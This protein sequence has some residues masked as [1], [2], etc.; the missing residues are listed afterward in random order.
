MTLHLSHLESKVVLNTCN[1][2][3]CVTFIIWFEVF[4]SKLS[5]FSQCPKYCITNDLQMTL[6]QLEEGVVGCEILS[7]R[8]FITFICSFPWIGYLCPAFLNC[9]TV[10]PQI[11]LSVYKSLLE[12]PLGL[13]RAWA[14]LITNLSWRMLI[15]FF[16]YLWSWLIWDTGSTTVLNYKIISLSFWI[17]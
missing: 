11:P 14:N 17:F 16:L 4:G 8:L 13:N 10:M 1:G 2:F 6:K 5:K 15:F 7:W 3:L 12:L 9:P